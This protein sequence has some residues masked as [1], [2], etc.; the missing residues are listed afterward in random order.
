M[1]SNGIK[2]KCSYVIMGLGQFLYGQ[3]IKGLLY[4]AVLA[5]YVWYLISTGIGDIA[6]FF[7][8]GTVEGDPWLGVQGD[9]SIIMMLRGILAFLIL[10]AVIVFYLSNIKDIKN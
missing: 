7:N 1:K 10:A 3:R 8:L 6:G 9:D 5:T 2:T 4:M